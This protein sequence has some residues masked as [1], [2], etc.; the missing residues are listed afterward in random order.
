MKRERSGVS[1]QSR[2][3]A[4]SS[5]IPKSDGGAPIWRY[6]FT[7]TVL[8]AAL[9]RPSRSTAVTKYWRW[10][11]PLSWKVFEVVIPRSPNEPEVLPR[12]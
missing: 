3:I 10:G 2:W 6:S 5:E 8:L 4:L 7:V 11:T 12:E 9:S 1:C